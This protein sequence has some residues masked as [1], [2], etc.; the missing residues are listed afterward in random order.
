MTKRT[1]QHD[2]EVLAELLSCLEKFQRLKLEKWEKVETEVD[3]TNLPGTPTEDWIIPPDNEILAN[4]LLKDSTYRK[5]REEIDRLRPEAI[6]IAHFLKMSSS[7]LEWLTF[8]NPLIGN[9]A[10]E[11]AIDHLKQLITKQKGTFY[12]LQKILA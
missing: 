5:L 4:I 9:D 12:L 6:H 11:S 1:K 7:P 2:S 10:L 3:A 8:I